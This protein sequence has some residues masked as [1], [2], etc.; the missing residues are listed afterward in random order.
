MSAI[1]DTITVLRPCNGQSLAKAYTIA[2][3][4]K[5]VKRDFPDVAMYRVTLEQ[6]D[7]IDSLHRLLERIER[8]PTACVIRG[9]PNAGADLN[10]ARR[11]KAENGGVFAD[12]PRR[13]LMVD[14]DKV[15]LPPGS[16]VIDDPQ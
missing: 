6:A 7:G 5:V 4:G 10:R 9:Q 12:V 11:K 16:S 8:D 3:N 15:P 2:S 13:W 1:A 14:L